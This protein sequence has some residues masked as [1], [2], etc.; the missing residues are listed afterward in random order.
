MGWGRDWGKSLFFKQG[1]KS[2]F[3][4]ADKEGE[5]DRKWVRMLDLSL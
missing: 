4:G 5:G 1:G 2:L 3:L